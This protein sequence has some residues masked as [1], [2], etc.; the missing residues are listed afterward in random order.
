MG[1]H[2][3]LGGGGGTTQYWK[4]EGVLR[5]GTGASEGIQICNIPGSIAT[6]THLVSRTR[7]HIA[8][9]RAQLCA[10]V[11]HTMLYTYIALNMVK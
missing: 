2:T 5:E 9:S 1:Y 8:L 7:H 11:T 6:V 3:V 4:G 10:P